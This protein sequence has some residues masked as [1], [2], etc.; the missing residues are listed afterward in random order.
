[1]EDIFG[2]G[3]VAVLGFVMEDDIKYVVAY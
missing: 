2:V 1:M 3:P